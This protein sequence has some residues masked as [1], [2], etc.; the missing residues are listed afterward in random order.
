MPSNPYNQPSIVSV[1]SFLRTSNNA[2]N[3]PGSYGEWNSY[4]ITPFVPLR[5]VKKIQ[6]VKAVIPNIALPLDDSKDLVFFYHKLTTANPTPVSANLRAV[7]LYPSS[8]YPPAGFTAFTKN[9]YVANGTELATLLNLAASTGGDSVSYNP[10]W[11]ANDITFTYNAATNQMTFKGNDATAGTSYCNAAYDSPLVRIYLISGFMSMNNPGLMSPIQPYIL[12][13]TM[14]LKLGYALSYNTVQPFNDGSPTLGAANIGG[15][16]IPSTSQVPVD[17][18]LNLV[19]TSA[20]YI[21]ASWA[22]TG[23]QSGQGN[24]NLLGVI[25]MNQPPFG[26]ITYQQQGTEPY[27]INVLSDIYDLTIELRTDTNNPYFLPDSASVNVVLGLEYND[28]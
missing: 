19:P 4:T 2:G 6:L 23:G 7:R 3:L 1:D 17:S 8:Y 18:Y 28:E 11:I 24:R 21:F 13:Y 12:G 5:N 26:L 15:E 22:G 25:P 16:G 9:R 27:L 10:I 14:N 20:I